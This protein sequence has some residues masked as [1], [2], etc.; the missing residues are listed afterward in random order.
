MIFLQKLKIIFISTIV[1]SLI[2]SAYLWYEGYKFDNSPLN[3]NIKNKI[4]TKQKELEY[5]AFKKFNVKRKI[6]IIISDKMPNKIYGMATYNENKIVIFLNKKRFK[7]SE[8]YMLNN[9]LPHEYAHALM[10]VF[11]DFT[12]EFGG[13]TIKWEKICK[14]LNGLKC[15]RFVD[16]KDIIIGKTNIF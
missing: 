13:H 15:D 9:V 2:L 11:K 10:F 5:L 4:V 1:I 14:K 12:Q 16:N 8:E 7:E 3:E 6:P